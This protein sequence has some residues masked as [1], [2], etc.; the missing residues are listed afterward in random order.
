MREPDQECGGESGNTQEEKKVDYEFS[1]LCQP[2]SNFRSGRV[3]DCK[4][5]YTN[6]SHTHQS[7]AYEASLQYPYSKRNI[8]TIV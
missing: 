6:I 4:L 1:I 5:E 7:R 2:A 8:D 3:E